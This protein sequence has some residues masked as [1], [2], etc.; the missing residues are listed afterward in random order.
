MKNK[1]ILLGV[2]PPPVGGIAQW[3]MR[4]MKA[5]LGDRWCLELIDE[6][7]LGNREF[8]GS[9]NKYNYFQE[10]K[11]WFGIW[12]KLLRALG[13]NSTKIVHSCPTAEM[14]SMMAEYV[15]AFLTKIKRKEFIIHFRCTIPNMIKTSFQK[16]LLIRFCNK[17]D[18]IIVLNEQSRCYLQELTKTEV[19]LISNFV[20]LSE[21]KDHHI[22][23]TINTVT[24]T[25]GVIPAKGCQDIIEYAK[26]FPEIEF[27]MVGKVNQAMLDLSKDIR[28]IVLTGVKSNEGVLEELNK[29]DV[30]I[31]ISR[32]IGEGFSNSLAEAMG[33]GVPCIVSD[34]A[35]NADMIDDGKGGVVL[36]N[37]DIDSF[38]RALKYMNS[39]EVRRMQ[40]EYNQRKVIS[41]YSEEI[42]IA[43]YIDCY[44]SLKGDLL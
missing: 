42:I 11:R 32:F 36:H 2:T 41:E 14:K 40:S 26:Y 28:N 6:K 8:F 21:I 13:D 25:G 44:D 12:Y 27:R 34:W 33:A 1:I 15:S 18:L 9:N 5:N 23:E 31:F 22:N 24:Y 19:R 3:T 43:K 39:Q 17:A 10:L 20:Y 16:R 35:A 29:A 4:M 38:S 37:Y 7:I 30:F